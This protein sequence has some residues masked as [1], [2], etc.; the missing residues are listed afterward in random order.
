[1]DASKLLAPKYA[2][3]EIVEA[4]HTAYWLA[5]Y[6]AGQEKFQVQEIHRNFAKLADV[7]GYRIEKITPERF[8]EPEIC[9][10][11]L[12]KTEAA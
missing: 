12:N 10:E 7:L 9:P 6:G 4:A 8:A 1:M 3:Q 11:P 5:S 2:A